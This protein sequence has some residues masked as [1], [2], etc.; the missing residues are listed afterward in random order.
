MKAAVYGMAECAGGMSGIGITADESSA[1]HH[2]SDSSSSSSRGGG[3]SYPYSSSGSSAGSAPSAGGNSWAPGIAMVSGALFV[4]SYRVVFHQAKKHGLTVAKSA[5]R[6]VRVGIPSSGSRPRRESKSPIRTQS[7]F[8]VSGTAAARAREPPPPDV[9]QAASPEIGAERGRSPTTL[10]PPPPPSS[11]RGTSDD[12]SKNL[13]DP[14][15]WIIPLTCILKVDSVVNDA[16]P[17]SLGVPFIVLKTKDGRFSKIEFPSQM[18]GNN[19]EFASNLARTLEK[20]VF[21]GSGDNEWGAFPLLHKAAWRKSC[22]TSPVTSPEVASGGKATVFGPAEF[23]LLAE[24][25]R[26]G[27]LN[28][29]SGL[30]CVKTAVDLFPN[31]P[32]TYPDAI[33]IPA[34]MTNDE[35][36]KVCAYRSKGRIPSVVYLHK[37]TNATISRSSQP[38]VGFTPG[39][40]GFGIRCLEDEKLLARIMNLVGKPRFFYIMDAR[41]KEAAT[42]NRFMGK[43]TEDVKNY[44]STIM[45][46]M[47]IAN[48]HSVRESETAVWELCRPT[49][50]VGSSDGFY[51]KLEATKWLQHVHSVLTAGAR[52][53]AIVSQEGASVLVHCSDGWD[54]TAQICGLAQIL[55]DPYYRTFTG[56]RAIIEKEWLDFGHK[57]ADRC[58]RGVSGGGTN[59]DE[60]S[61]IFALW[62]DCVWQCMRQFPEAFEF[63]ENLLLALLDQLHA[64]RCG[65]FL[66]NSRKERVE[67]NLFE[68][69]MN[70]WEFFEKTGAIPS[71]VNKLYVK[72]DPNCQTDLRPSC[73]PKNVKFFE[74]YFLRFDTSIVPYKSPVTYF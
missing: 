20:A 45:V 70:V 59:D 60:R 68:R 69:T 64:G 37:S 39:Y 3:S 12:S 35:L 4:T 44:H 66:C 2:L 32:T 14:D 26:I 25:E 46:H 63:N 34:G 24:Y 51:G 1:L 41:K 73:N 33:M 58:G 8:G 21:K 52:C 36:K 11:S 30:R 22:I 5:T 55:I 43:G 15:D 19:S 56:F 29:S 13:P 71:F 40:N 18:M 65:T 48:I 62:L 42:G 49:S 17:K 53:A 67:E 28:E 61:P 10:L 6:N 23:S 16:D 74:P 38:L 47:D 50:T 57:F 72:D 7:S 9:E 27:L 54:R 31:A